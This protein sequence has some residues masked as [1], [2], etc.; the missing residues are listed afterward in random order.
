M[1]IVNFFRSCCNSSE[2]ESSSKKLES[3][4]E[5]D[6]EVSRKKQKSHEIQ[7]NEL[8][9]LIRINE[10][11]EQREEHAQKS[12]E[13]EMRTPKFACDISLEENPMD[14]VIEESLYQAEMEL[15]KHQKESTHKLSTK[16]PGPCKSSKLPVVLT[17]IFD[18]K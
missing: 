6:W 3:S 5:K 12:S 2:V 10:N 9:S 16:K 11:E 17:L 14:M 15:E 13:E 4:F 7:R 8:V 18:H 1:E